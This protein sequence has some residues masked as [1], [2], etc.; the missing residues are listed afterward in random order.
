MI[1]VTRWHPDTCSCVIDFEWDDTDPPT[2]RSHTFKQA[3]FLCPDH[4]GLKGPPLLD[5]VLEENTRKNRVLTLAQKLDPT[6]MSDDF[7]KNNVWWFDSKRTLHVRI[8][9]LASQKAQF[10]NLANTTLG[11]DG[12]QVE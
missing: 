10:Q 8:P 11:A 9:R 2:D 1:H 3:V 4:V 6:I 7:E 5:V 12:V